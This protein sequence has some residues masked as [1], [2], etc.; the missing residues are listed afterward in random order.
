M[1]RKRYL[2][3]PSLPL[4]WLLAVTMTAGVMKIFSPD[5]RLGF[6]SQASVLDARIA[7]GGTA[8]QIAEWQRLIVSNRV[9]AVLTGAFL[10]L[11]ALVVLASMRVWLQLLTGRRIADLHEEPYVLF[12]DRNEGR[13][14]ENKGQSEPIQLADPSGAGTLTSHPPKSGMNRTAAACAVAGLALTAIAIHWLNGSGSEVH[15]SDYYTGYSH[16]HS[17][18]YDRRPAL[19]AVACASLFTVVS[20]LALL[21][22]RPGKM[23]AKTQEPNNTLNHAGIPRCAGAQGVFG[24]QL[25]SIGVPPLPLRATRQTLVARKTSVAL[26]VG[27]D[28]DPS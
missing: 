10:V 4:A 25:T 20:A 3:V 24:V 21:W 26:E 16:V 11:V 15:V 12:G 14:Q 17:D 8:A 18:R 7:A 13:M 22:S 5:P 23:G 19:A 9:D 1:G 28:R 2:W 27:F 6:L